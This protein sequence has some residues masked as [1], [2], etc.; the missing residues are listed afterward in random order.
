ML[1]SRRRRPVTQSLGPVPRGEVGRG[2]GKPTSLM[3]RTALSRSKL[4]G[5]SELTIPGGEDIGVA[6]A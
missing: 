2:T 1:G 5:C 3:K 6:S 4:V